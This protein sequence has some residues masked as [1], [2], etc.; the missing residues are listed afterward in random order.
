MVEAEAR[1]V[2]AEARVGRGDPE[3][4]RQRETEAAAHGRA[5]TAATI[6]V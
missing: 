6:G 4:R 1:E 3:V 5:C 2:R